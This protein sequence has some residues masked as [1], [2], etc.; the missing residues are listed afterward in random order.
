L[1]FA[2]YVSVYGAVLA[3]FADWDALPDNYKAYYLNLAEAVEADRMKVEEPLIV[4]GG[5]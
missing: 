1:L 5:T 2:K 4:G 3:Q